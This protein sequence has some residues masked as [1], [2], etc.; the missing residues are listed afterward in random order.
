M[1]PGHTHGPIK[2]PTDPGQSGGPAGSAGGQ[3]SDAG[4]PPGARPPVQPLRV[5]PGFIRAGFH[6]TGQGPGEDK[7]GGGLECAAEQ[8]GGAA[9]LEAHDPPVLAMGADLG[10]FHL[11]KRRWPGPGQR[12]SSCPLAS[13]NLSRSKTGLAGD[14]LIFRASRIPA[15]WARL[16]L[17]ADPVTTRGSPVMALCRAASVVGI[18]EGGLAIF[19]ERADALDSVGMDGGAPVCLHHDRDGLLDRLALAHP[20]RLLDGLYRGG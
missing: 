3:P 15:A 11:A 2:R 10:E 6:A 19:V 9:R 7:R 20:D 8:I 16:S 4:V 17:S 13:E 1:P 14:L 5:G 12:A 18:G